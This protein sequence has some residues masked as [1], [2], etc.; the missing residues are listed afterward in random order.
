M[1]YRISAS[2]P[3]PVPCGMTGAK[4]GRE[5]G[6]LAGKEIDRS[7]YRGYIGSMEA[8]RVFGT[9]RPLAAGLSRELSNR[10]RRSDG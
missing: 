3:T 1:R 7:D 2:P 4:T 10:R 5:K 6:G 9:A 8:Y